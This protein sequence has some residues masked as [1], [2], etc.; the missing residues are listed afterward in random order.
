MRIEIPTSPNTDEG[1]I[2]I[3]VYDQAGCMAVAT[4]P[5]ENNGNGVGWY[6]AIDVPQT[7]EL[8][9]TLLRNVAKILDYEKENHIPKA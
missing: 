1:Y 8:V 5:T 4:C 6:L 9:Q 2:N 7:L 3:Q